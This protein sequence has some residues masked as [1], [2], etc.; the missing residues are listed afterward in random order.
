MTLSEV[1]SSTTGVPELRKQIAQALSE[2]D[3]PRAVRLALRAVREQGMPI[4]DLYVC[5]LAPLLAEI[6]TEWQKGA[7][8]IWQ[9]HFASATIRTIVESLYDDVVRQAERVPPRNQVAILAC[10]EEERHDLGLR[11]LADRM[12]LAGWQVVFLGASTPSAEIIG[13]ARAADA[14]VVVLAVATH[15]NR[16]ELRRTLEKIRASLPGVRV[17]VGGPAFEQ[18]RS[19]DWPEEDLV[20]ESSLGVGSDSGCGG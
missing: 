4:P 16:V 17:D 12:M 13:A 15:F 1:R 11:M 10:P 18:D 9:E 3:R 6:G 7:T 20:T 19:G 5:V 2:R 14:D 8:P